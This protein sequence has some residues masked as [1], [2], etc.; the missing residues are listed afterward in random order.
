MRPNEKETLGAWLQG[1]RNGTGWFQPRASG[2][3]S[4]TGATNV[5]VVA[6]VVVLRA[7]NVGVESSRG[8]RRSLK[9]I[10]QLKTIRRFGRDR[11]RTY[12]DERRARV[13]DVVDARA[14]RKSVDVRVAWLQK[15]RVQ[16]IEG[17]RC[18]KRMVS[19]NALPE[20]CQ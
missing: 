17:G 13:E 4:R 5:S 12:H 11:S 16:S 8:T 6:V 3:D 20:I 1:C 15:K 18:A 19:Q 2:K 14:G 9:R 10:N 7:G